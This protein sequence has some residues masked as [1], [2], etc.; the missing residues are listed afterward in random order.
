MDK[1]HSK[2]PAS[3]KAS[4]SSMGEQYGTTEAQGERHG[5]AVLE[6]HEEDGVGTP[7]WRAMGKVRDQGGPGKIGDQGPVLERPHF[8]TNLTE[9]LHLCPKQ[10]ESCQETL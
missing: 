3:S 4:G 7:F 1:I 8:P 5:D 2:T 10:L 9:Q 6:R